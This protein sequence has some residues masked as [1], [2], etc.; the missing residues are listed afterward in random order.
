MT[1]YQDI[2]N[3][4][5]GPVIKKMIVDMENSQSIVFM[6]TGVHVLMSSREVKK[7]MR[8]NGSV[9]VFIEIFPDKV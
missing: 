9:R 1:S 6:N 8:K 2:V 4:Y 3:S 5:S 7:S